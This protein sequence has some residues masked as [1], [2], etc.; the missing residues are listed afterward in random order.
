MYL[1]PSSFPLPSSL[2]PN[3]LLNEISE[4]GGQEGLQQ[5]GKVGGVEL[6]DM[7]HHLDN[8]HDTLCLDIT[9]VVPTSLNDHLTTQLQQTR[10]ILGQDTTSNRNGAIVHITCVNCS[11]LEAHRTI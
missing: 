11:G 7:F 2:P 4:H 10:S 8:D 5:H 1:P 6:C 3:L 9:E